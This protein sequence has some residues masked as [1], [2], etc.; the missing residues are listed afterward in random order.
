[1]SSCGSCSS[2]VRPSAGAGTLVQIRTG[3]RAR[4]ND[5]TL[6]VEAG[7]SQCAIT[8]QGPRKAETLY[9]AYRSGMH[10]A[11]VAAAEFAIF[12]QLGFESRLTPDRLE[13]ELS[14]EPYW[15]AAS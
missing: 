3:Y 10:A 13:Q 4:W 12:R 1:M 6:S 5:L 14:W 9:T 15:Q 8:V 11:R 2:P 7:A